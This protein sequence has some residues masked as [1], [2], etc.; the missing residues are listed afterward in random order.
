MKNKKQRYYF[1][2]ELFDFV[3]GGLLVDH[4]RAEKILGFT[5]TDFVSSFKRMVISAAERTRHEE[6]DCHL[7]P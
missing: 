7:R 4:S 5:S 6:T 1:N 2:K 3:S